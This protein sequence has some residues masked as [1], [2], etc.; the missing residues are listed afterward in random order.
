MSAAAIYEM[1]K[2]YQPETQNEYCEIA[3]RASIAE[4][5]VMPEHLIRSA[6]IGLARGLF[7]EAYQ[8]A[9]PRQRRKWIDMAER[10]YR[11]AI[12]RA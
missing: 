12:K 4:H 9:P 8:D 1:I 11:R 7:G 2:V 6:A 5:G 10:E 3:A